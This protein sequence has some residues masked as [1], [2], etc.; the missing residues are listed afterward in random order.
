MLI[1]PALQLARGTEF[2]DDRPN[3]NLNLGKRS[4][5]QPDAELT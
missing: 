3:Y 5:A 1:E 4:P 2:A